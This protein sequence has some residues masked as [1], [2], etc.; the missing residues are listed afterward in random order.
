MKPIGKAWLAGLLLALA[1]G[2]ALAE[3]TATIDREQVAMGDTL[4]LTI[5][6]TDGED[7]DGMD[8]RPLLGD[9]DILQRSTSSS[10]RIVN[11]RAS[12][13]RTVNLDISPKR[14]GNLRIPAMRVDNTATPLILVSVGPA[15]TI[16]AESDTVVFE[17]EVDRDRVYVQGQLLLTLRVQQA[18]NLDARSITELQLDDAFVKPLE[19]RSFQRKVNGRP[20]LVHEVRYAIFPEQSGTLEIPAQTFTAREAQPR[21]S[22]FDLGASGRPVRRTTEALRIDVLPRPADFPGQTWLPAT[23]VEIEESWS[24]PPESLKAGE[25]ATR[26]LRIVGEGLQGAQ[27]PP[28][29]IPD[30]GGLKFY[31][32]QPAISDTETGAGLTGVRVDSAALV[33]TQAGSWELPEIR[34][35][36]WDTASESV[37]YA[38][39][40]GRRVSVTGAAASALTVPVPVTSVP[41]AV[42]PEPTAIT[43][44]GADD[45]IW[46]VATAIAVLGWLLT[47]LAWLWSRRQRK[48]AIANATPENTSESAA[49]RNLAAACAAGQPAQARRALIAWANARTTE[50]TVTRLADVPATL[51]GDL[52]QWSAALAALEASNYR[53]GG[54][55]WTGTALL[56]LAKEARRKDRPG[57][58]RSDP[59]LALY[60]A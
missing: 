39:V 38:V 22:L 46:Q 29:A 28:V 41:I 42:T 60:P 21:R 37:R 25:S 17:A 58:S 34:I 56:E 14:E 57:A 35:P 55:P 9:F 24:V 47:A 2:T 13:T 54:D 19:Q 15:P 5:T 16:V 23:S 51:D 12:S 27:L 32:D 59:T 52:D 53:D 1:C 44:A 40:P 7:V 31:P 4:R 33:P 43:V 48:P 20:W 30:L 50:S 26:T 45:S 6:A 3:V 11:G 49:F 18:V 10:T 36:W 8:L